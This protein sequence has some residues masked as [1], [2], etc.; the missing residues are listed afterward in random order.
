MVSRSTA[1]AL[2]ARLVTFTTRLAVIVPISHVSGMFRLSVCDAPRLPGATSAGM[3]VCTHVVAVVPTI[4]VP[5]VVS[6]HSVAGGGLTTA[7]VRP[8]MID[9][10]VAYSLGRVHVPAAAS[11]GPFC[12]AVVCPTQSTRSPDSVVYAPIV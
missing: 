8:A 6:T 10:P 2:G 4:T 1:W 3:S 5:A 11:H 9:A 12:E 7:T